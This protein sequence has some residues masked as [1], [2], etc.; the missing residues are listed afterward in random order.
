MLRH[1]RVQSLRCHICA[2]GQRPHR[3]GRR[4]SVPETRLVVAGGG[5]PARSRTIQHGRGRD[6]WLWWAGKV[7]SRAGMSAAGVSARA[8]EDDAYGD[9]ADG[10]VDVHCDVLPGC[11]L[12][13]GMSTDG[14]DVIEF[15]GP[16]PTAAADRF[17]LDGEKQPWRRRWRREKNLEFNDSSRQCIWYSWRRFCLI[18]SRIRG[19]RRRSPTAPRCL[20]SR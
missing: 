2:R 12:H 10:S 13:I 11:H 14:D 20:R 17:D 3:E 9:L 19:M 1:A 15:G 18:A 7:L 8:A 6:A 5:D 4:R 16:Q